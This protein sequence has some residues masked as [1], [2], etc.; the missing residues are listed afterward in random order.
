MFQLLSE[1]QNAGI[2]IKNDIKT[3]EKVEIRATKFVAE[4]RHKSFQRRFRILCLPTLKF[5][6]LRGGMIEIYK[7]LSGMH[8]TT[9]VT[10]KN[11][12][13]RSQSVARIGGRTAPQL[14]DSN[15]NCY[16]DILGSKLL[17]SQVSP[18]GVT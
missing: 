6:R 10:T 15:S 14:T 9:V 2:L 17:G 3:L 12:D 7:V 18:F 13:T 8:D 1:A 11:A 4:L 5:R 16:R